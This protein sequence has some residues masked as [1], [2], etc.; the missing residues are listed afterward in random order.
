MKCTMLTSNFKEGFTHEI[1]T[2]IKKVIVGGKFTF[3]SSD[4]DTNFEKTD[5][6]FKHYCD[7]F[8]SIGIRFEQRCVVDKRIA[9]AEAK[10]AIASANVI[11]LS[12]GNTFAHFQHINSYDLVDTILN[13]DGVV[14]GMSAGAI[15]MAKTAICSTTKE[16][17]EYRV[18]EA[19]GLT[20]FTIVPHF[21]KDNIH[22]ALLAHSFSFPLYGVCDN[23]A[24]ITA[25]QKTIFCG[26]VYLLRNGCVEKTIS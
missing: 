22:P 8:S 2:E 12:G 14:I 7:M 19:L 16:R 3:V 18:Y 21:V 17:N 25:E 5:I 13:F 15:N 24:I 11:W 26:E 10:A 6:Y 4:F 23:A 9:E 20:D 1:A